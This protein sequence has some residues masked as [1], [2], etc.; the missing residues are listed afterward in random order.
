MQDTYVANQVYL[1]LNSR[2]NI[3]MQAR[4]YNTALKLKSQRTLSLTFAVDTL[5]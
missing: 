4:K 2:Q 3:Y 5:G 1:L